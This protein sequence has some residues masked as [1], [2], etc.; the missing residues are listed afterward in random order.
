MT[1]S[2]RV[3]ARSVQRIPS[4]QR[5]KAGLV[6][7]I[8][9]RPFA[10]NKRTGQV[11]NRRTLQTRVASRRLPE[12]SAAARVSTSYT[13]GTVPQLRPTCCAKQP[14]GTHPELVEDDAIAP[15]GELAAGADRP[16]KSPAS[17]R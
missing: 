14:G 12:T 4:G 1:S 15:F 16:P 17:R 9:G 10:T 7:L 8:T 13:S 11:V 2:L 3:L 5:T 6:K